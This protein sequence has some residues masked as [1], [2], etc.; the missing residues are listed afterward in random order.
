M[1]TELSARYSKVQSL[2]ATGESLVSKGHPFKNR[3]QNRLAS[4]TE[5]WTNLRSLLKDFLQSM[6][7]SLEYF[8]YHSDA[9]EI[10]SWLKESLTILTGLDT[11]AD[12]NDVEPLIRRHHNLEEE[13]SAFEPDVKRLGEQS[14]NLQRYGAIFKK[15][16]E[17]ARTIVSPDRELARSVSTTEQIE[18]QKIPQVINF[19]ELL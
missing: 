1:E 9:N 16:S 3:I 18:E 19:R 8:H 10:E 5:H 11:A 4:L 14:Q 2:Q 13:I 12:V 15:I 6:D 17:A 7:A